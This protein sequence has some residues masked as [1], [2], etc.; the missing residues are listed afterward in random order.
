MTGVHTGAAT[1]LLGRERE[2][3]ELYGALSLALK[4][5]SQIVVVAGDAGAGKTTLVAD[6]ARRAEELGFAVA[7]GHCLDIDADISFAP[8]VE[9]VRALVSGVEDLD[10]RPVARRMRGVLDPGTPRPAEQVNLLDDLRLTVLEAAAAGPVMLVLEDLHW[11]DTSTRDLAVALSRTA[12]G[13]LMLVLTVRTDDLHRRHPARAALAEIGRVPGG[14]RVELKPLDHHSIAAIA[15]SISG[16]RPDTALVRSVVERSEG[17]PLYAEEIAAAGE[18]DVPEELSDLFLA[19]I[20]ALDVGP[21]ELARMASVDGSQ[22]DVETLREL[23][24]GVDPDRF[25][26]SLRD[27]HDANILRRSGD[28]LEFR[29]GL[30]REAVHDD[31]L[32]D[33]RTRIHAELATLLQKRVDADPDPRLSVLSRLA[34]HAAEAHDLSRALVASERA[35]MWP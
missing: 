22:V 1:A 27:L 15:A 30:L 34:L 33:E 32:P 4:A 24:A 5:E 29:H 10:V 3:A 25:T 2:Q 18:G 7:V 6:L 26:A 17:N 14:R 31:L 21:R 13:R 23:A 16:S 12:R 35:G 11:A 28:S 9:A 20:D 8:V 19:R